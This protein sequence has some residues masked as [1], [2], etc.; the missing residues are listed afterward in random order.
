M[1]QVADEA[2]TVRRSRTTPLFYQKKRYICYNEGVKFVVGAFLAF[3]IIQFAILFISPFTIPKDDLF[4]YHPGHE[5]RQF[6][7]LAPLANFDGLHYISIAKNGYGI[8][9]QAFFPLYPTI[10]RTLSSFSITPLLTGIVV[11]IVFFFLTLLVL[12]SYFQIILHDERKVRWALLFLFVFP[13]SFFFETVYAESL[14]LFLVTST[15]SLIAK[16]QYKVATIPAVL[17][18]LCKTQGILLIIPFIASILLRSKSKRNYKMLLFS[19]SPFV[20]LAIYASYL[21]I[22]YKD[23]LYFYHVQSGFG[24]QRTSEKIILLPQVLFRYLKIFF[25]ADKTFQYTIAVFEFAIFATVLSVLCVATIT[26]LKEKN[27]RMLPLLLFSLANILLPTFTGTL[28][29]IPRYALVSLGLFP[30][31]ANLKSNV[32]KVATLFVFALAHVVFFVYFLQGFFV[33]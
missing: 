27:R 5:E 18:A 20:G 31:L 11:S 13:T 33:S 12:R 23:P 29:S 32:V 21:F 14:F 16:E 10:I 2:T 8:L 1:R 24:A 26:I 15:F 22:A 7:A 3:T 25:T 17:A 6:A 28:S 4:L 30:I 19:L 9:Q